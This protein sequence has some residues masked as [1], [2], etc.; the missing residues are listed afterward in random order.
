MT[1]GYAPA[2]LLGGR[3]AAHIVLR[4]ELGRLGEVYCTTDN[5]E[6][7]VQWTGNGSRDPP[8]GGV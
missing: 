6:L 1:E 7:G 3:T 8:G 4:E 2:V 5:G